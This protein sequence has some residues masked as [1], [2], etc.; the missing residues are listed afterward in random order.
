[1]IRSF[2]PLLLGL[3]LAACAGAD[4]A[5]SHAP[6]DTAGDADADTDSDADADTDSDADADADTDSDADADTDSDTDSDPIGPAGEFS[7]QITVDGVLRSYEL[8]VPAS[9]TAAMQ[10]APVPVLITL[11][12][13]GD[14]GYNFIHATGLTSTADSQGFVLVGPDA[15]GGGWF[16]QQ[17]EGWPGADGNSMSLQNDMELML[18]ILDELEAGYRVD[19]TRYYAAG[20]SRGG[21]YTALMASLSSQLSIASGTWV[22]PFAAYGINAG[23]DPAGGHFDMSAAT[24]KRPIWVIHGT[25]DSTV[26]YSYGE[27][28]AHELQIAGWDVTFT[29]VSGGGHSWLWRSNYGQTNDDLLAYFLANP[30]P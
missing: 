16:L 20:H 28:L 10:D 21:G 30:I 4:P 3:A 18:T 13:A 24:P 8:Y 12:G 14:T 17:N 7:E 2:L 15:Y 5:D 19:D 1:M 11:H 25:S 9:A 22:S 29:S 6:H 27:D 26:P 23:Y